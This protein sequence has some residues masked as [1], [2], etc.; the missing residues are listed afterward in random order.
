MFAYI[1]IYMCIHIY[2]Y[3]HIYI[4]I[5]NVYLYAY[6]CNCVRAWTCSPASRTP[7]L[8]AAATRCKA[9][10]YPLP[11]GR[12]SNKAFARLCF[13][14]TPFVC[15]VF[16]GKPKGKPRNT[17]IYSI[18]FGGFRKTTPTHTPNCCQRQTLQPALPVP[19][20]IGPGS[21]HSSKRIAPGYLL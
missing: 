11:K 7:H 1:Y 9:A 14:S 10:R 4:Y 19:V 3:V 8:L 6:M 15:Q 18:C 13:G 12:C 17:S 20:D 5:Y 21:K 2:T 16:K